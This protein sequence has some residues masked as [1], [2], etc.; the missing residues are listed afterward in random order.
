MSGGGFV[1]APEKVD[2]RS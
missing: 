1:R 2:C